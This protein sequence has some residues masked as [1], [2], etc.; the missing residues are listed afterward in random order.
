[1]QVRRFDAGILCMGFVQEPVA[2]TTCM[3]QNAAIALFQRRY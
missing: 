3:R 2:I 1:M